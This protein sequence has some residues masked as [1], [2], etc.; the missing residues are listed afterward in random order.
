MRT[1]EAAK[2]DRLDA[3]FLELDDLV[4][5][6]A[7]DA[8]VAEADDLRERAQRVVVVDARRVYELDAHRAG[9]LA[10]QLEEAS[11]R[12]PTDRVVEDQRARA[13]ARRTPRAGADLGQRAVQQDR[14]RQLFATATTRDLRDLDGL[15]AACRIGV[16][17]VDLDR[18]REATN[19]ALDEREP[20]R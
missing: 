1:L 3:A 19:R 10:L 8:L 2:L 15:A 13:L 9:D 11:A 7:I 12:G 5:G 20:R 14:A 6:A 17:H 18:A 16:E 4:A